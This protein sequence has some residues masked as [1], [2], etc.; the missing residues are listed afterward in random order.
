MT[1]EVLDMA[2]INQ[3]EIRSE[4]KVLCPKCQTEGKKSKVIYYPGQTIPKMRFTD[5]YW[6]EDG[7]FIEFNEE[8][9]AP[10][11]TCCNGHTTPCNQ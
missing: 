3:I 11:Y 9:K 4:A 5:G 1:L 6:N 8:I 2:A 10:S 7:D